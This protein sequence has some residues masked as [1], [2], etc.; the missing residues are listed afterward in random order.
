M[1][2][3]ITLLTNWHKPTKVKIILITCHLKLILK[4]H[5]ASNSVYF[6]PTFSNFNYFTFYFNDINI[7][8][9][10]LTGS[11]RIIEP[12]YNAPCTL[13]NSALSKNKDIP[14]YKHAWASYSVNITLTQHHLSNVTS[15]MEIVLN[16]ST[17]FFLAGFPNPV[18]TPGCQMHPLSLRSLTGTSSSSIP[19]VSWKWYLKKKKISNEGSSI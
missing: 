5:P 7:T 8:E 11:H 6:S 17:M 14:L 4:T 16:V 10:H 13:I 9:D 2:L 12:L 15:N 18:T 19:N 3:F 1:K